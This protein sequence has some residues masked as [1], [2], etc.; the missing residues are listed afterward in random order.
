[1]TTKLV[2]DGL[3]IAR[4]ATEEDNKGNLE[5][6]QELYARA[7]EHLISGMKCT[8]FTPYT[9]APLLHTHAE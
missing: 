1:M 4:E 2:K 5:K 7:C 3:V 9:A 8:S 6:A